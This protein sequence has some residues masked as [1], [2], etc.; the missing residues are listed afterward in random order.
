[1]FLGIKLSLAVS[2]SFFVPLTTAQPATC[3]GNPDA[4]TAYT[5]AID[6]TFPNALAE[7][8]AAVSAFPSSNATPEDIDVSRV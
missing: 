3:G 6:I 5:N 7:Y 8:T 4:T 1:M 2:F